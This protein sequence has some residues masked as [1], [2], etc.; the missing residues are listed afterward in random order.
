MVAGL[1]KR[2]L[3]LEDKGAPPDRLAVEVVAQEM[4]G[5]EVL[6]FPADLQLGL[7]G[8]KGDFLGRGGVLDVEEALGG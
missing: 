4:E 2:R 1:A 6:G 5:I 7:P 8:V 3:V